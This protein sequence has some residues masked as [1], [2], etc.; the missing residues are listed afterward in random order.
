M[1]LLLR[2]VN[3]TNVN[4]QQTKIQDGFE[5]SSCS[6]RPETRLPSGYFQVDSYMG[7]KSFKII[8]INTV[9]IFKK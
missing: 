1:R 2:K 5:L 7:R 8:G 9:L 6:S 4:K 3:G